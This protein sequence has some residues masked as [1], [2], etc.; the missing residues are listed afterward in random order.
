MARVRRFLAALPA[1]RIF[2]VAIQQWK[3]RRSNEQN[4]YLWGAVY[5]AI[6]SGGGEPLRGWT[7]DD[8][9]EY[10]L[11]EWSGW[12]LTEAFGKKRQRPVRR[13]SSLN[14]Q[15]F[16]DFIEFIRVRMIEHGITI[17]EAGEEIEA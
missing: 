17:P 15:E 2:T 9:H 6:L 4:A 7:A 12:E 1:D 14:K 11:G 8:L 3:P 10:C 13:S 16:S 5:P